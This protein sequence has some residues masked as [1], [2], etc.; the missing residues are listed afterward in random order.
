MTTNQQENDKQLRELAWCLH[1]CDGKYGDDGELQCNRF[2]GPID[3]KRDPWEKILKLSAHHEHLLKQEL[4]KEAADIIRNFTD[5]EPCQFD[6]HGNCQSHDMQNPCKMPAAKKFVREFDDSIQTPFCSYCGTKT[7]SCVEF[8]REGDS[9]ECPKCHATFEENPGYGYF[10]TS[11]GIDENE[12]KEE[13]F[14]TGT[15]KPID[16]NKRPRTPEG[17]VRNCDSPEKLQKY[18]D[19]TQIM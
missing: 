17:I 6:H 19:E 2:I 10:A 3:F 8:I 16:P 11:W 7:F 13:R 15:G 18:L 5:D 4:R 9:W 12:H 1:P 14:S